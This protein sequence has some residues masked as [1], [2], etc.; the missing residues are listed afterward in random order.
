MEPNRL[1]FGSPGWGITIQYTLT[2][3]WIWQQADWPQFRWNLE[4]LHL[5]L[6]DTHKHMGLLLGRMGNLDEGLDSAS[7]LDTLLQNIVT[8][9]AIEG[10]AVN[11]ASVRSSLAKRL[12]LVTGNSSPTS[13]KTEGLAE[14]MVELNS[15]SSRRRERLARCTA[16]C[17]PR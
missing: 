3:R 9:S 14:L 5:Q 8:S 13:S 4:R 12:G 1:L 10:E 2:D 7:A 15:D 17:S 11:A 16:G 6:G